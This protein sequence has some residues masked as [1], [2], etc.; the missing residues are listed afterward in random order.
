M[1]VCSFVPS[2]HSC[3]LCGT[4]QSLQ[5]LQGLHGRQDQS[6]SSSPDWRIVLDLGCVSLKSSPHLTRRL[7]DTAVRTLTN[8]LDA[9]HRLAVLQKVGRCMVHGRC[10]TTVGTTAGWHHCRATLACVPSGLLWFASGSIRR[11]RCGAFSCLATPSASA[12][13]AQNLTVPSPRETPET[14]A[15]WSERFVDIEYLRDTAN[16]RLL[17]S[18]R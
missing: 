3:T 15:S 17:R 5:G 13:L 9:D 4:L 18:L 14:F 10:I 16:L 6:G 2:F 7:K 1:F 12:C 8:A 11:C